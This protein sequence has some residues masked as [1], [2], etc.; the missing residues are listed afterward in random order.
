VT[1]LAGTAGML[2]SED[3]TGAAARFNFPT[4]VAVD[5]TGNLYV[6]DSGNHTVRKITPTGVVT[7]LAGSPGSTGSTDGTGPA[8]RFNFPSG[9]AIDGAG[10][11]YV[12]DQVNSI[13][14]KV[15]A[16]GVVT[17]LAGTPG[18]PGSADG[19]AAAAGFNSPTGV[20]V[21]GAGNVYVVDNGNATVRKIT[22]AGVVTTLAGT[23]GMSGS[24][25]GTGAAARFFFPTGV[26][27]DAAGT[28]YVGDFATVRKITTAGTVTTLA[29]TAGMQGS[30]DGTGA[31]ARFFSAI[32]VA[33]DRAGNVYVA[34]N[35][36]SDIRKVTAAGRVTTFAGPSGSEGSADGRGACA[37][38]FFPAGVAADAAGNVY[39]ADTG[40]STL[41]KVT[42]AG[43]VTTL[44][45]TAGASGSSDGTGADAQFNGPVAVAVDRTGNVYVADTGGPTLRKVTAAGVVTTLAGSAGAFGS[46]DG[47]GAAARFSSPVAVA[48]D[49]AGNVYVAD[50][51]TI[52]K[53][54]PAGVVTTLAGAAGVT[55][56]ADGTGAAARFNN[57]TGIAVDSTGNVHVA[58]TVNNTIRKV[59]PAGVVTTLAGTAGAFGS[60][61]GTGPAARFSFPE[62]V[63]VDGAG[64]VHVA[65]TG[66]RALRR[67]TPNG[68][69]T[70]VGVASALLGATPSFA[71]PAH[72][73]IGGDAIVVIAYNAIFLLRHGAR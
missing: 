73:A 64:N 31:A 21:D 20:A 56:S 67:V 12:A 1:T 72:L 65:D 41:R 18:V 13:I 35:G 53:V 68:A 52:R 34:D 51:D 3:G 48:V 44:A 11:L 17:T 47:T 23:A 19:P 25:D 38:F 28:V 40:N 16:A 39:V 42:A 9:V 50:N 32:G 7:T 58:D 66:N 4:S 5:G 24:A 26:A 62:G 71:F 59:S 27:V 6:G 45:G 30:A 37:R 22:V 36:N 70:T 49:P 29:G 60:A 63:A 43:V 33:V 46:A 8:A 54:S 10:N 15:T 55:G 61:D 57:P 69:T 2:G 14:R